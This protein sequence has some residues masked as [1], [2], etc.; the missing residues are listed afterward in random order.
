MV[1]T[2]I[3]ADRLRLRWHHSCRLRRAAGIIVALVVLL[4]ARSP[5]SQVPAPEL[6]VCGW[7]EVFVLKFEREEPRRRW[8][9]RAKGRADL[10]ND[11]QSLFNTTDECKPFDGGSRV[12]ITSSGGAVALVDRVHDRVLFYGRAANAHSADLLPGGR[13]A[14]AASHHATAKGDRLIVFDLAK[15]NQ[16][17]LSEELPWGHGVVW[18]EQRKLLWA[19]AD[20][21]IRVY[22]LRDWHTASPKLRRVALIPLPEAGGH[23]FSVVDGS[24]IAVSTATR[25]WLFDRQTRTF[26]PHP[27]LAD[28]AKVKSIS[29]DP[30]TGRLAYVQAEG[31]NW[32]AERI[33]FLNPHGTLHVPG[34]HFYKAR[35]TAGLK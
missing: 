20:N 13:V 11:F 34:E 15:S 3:F 16:E 22:E 23:D 29:R 30:T 14:V 6:I 32:W 31:Q 12:L 25:C 35:W 7:D 17:L 8:T 21:D 24:V 18:D 2:A 4:A 10:P 28:K 26:R 9:W 5:A 1:G 19:L 27:E 33:H